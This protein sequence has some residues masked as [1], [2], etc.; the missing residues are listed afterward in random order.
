[1]TPARFRDFVRLRDRFRADC[2]DW[3]AALPAL[4][5]LQDR[6]R[7]ERGYE[8]YAIETPVVYN[9]ALDAIREADEPTCILVGDNPGKNEQLARNRRYLVGQSGKLAEGFFRRELGADF[10]REVIIINKTPVHTPKTA[11]LR[12]LLGLAG[13]HGAESRAALESLL[14]ESQRSMARLARGLQA[15]LGLPLWITGYGELG[16]RGLFRDYAAA[17]GEAY[18]AAPAAERDKV[19]LFRHFSMNQFAIELKEKRDQRRSLLED[20]ELIGLANRKRILGW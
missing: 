10:R 16:P 4:A 8:D 12:R 13:E 11:E 17:L 5:E 19:W 2:A 9:E 20:L 6:L 18:A 15:A 14:A 7:R 1:M 3:A